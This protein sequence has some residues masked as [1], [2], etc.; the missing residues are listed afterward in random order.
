MALTLTTEDRLRHLNIALRKVP[1]PFKVRNPEELRLTSEER[2]RL[3]PAISRYLR[4]FGLARFCEETEFPKLIQWMKQTGDVKVSDP[5]YERAEQRLMNDALYPY[6][7]TDGNV[8]QAAIQEAIRT[9][10]DG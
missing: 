1:L 5:L 10:S 3:E 2:E 9:L 8:T 6:A 4:I 7:D